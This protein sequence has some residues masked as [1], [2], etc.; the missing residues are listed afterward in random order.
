MNHFIYIHILKSN[1]K[2]EEKMEQLLNVGVIG[3][4]NCGGQIAD[5]ASAEGFEAIAINASSDDMRLLVNKVEC[6]LVGDGK[7]TG[8]NRENAKEF[9]RAHSNIFKDDRLVKFVTD[10][11][12]IVVVASIGGGFGSGASL[13]ATSTLSNDYPDRL[14]IPAGIMPFDSEGYTAQN[15]SIEWEQELEEMQIPY[16]LYDNDRY[17][18]KPE[19]EV[20]NIVNSN[21]IND[22]KVIRG[23][24]IYATRIGGIDARDIMTTLSTPGRIVIGSMV[25]ISDEDVIEKSLIT[26]IK[27]HIDTETAHAAMVDDKQILASATMYCLPEEFDLFKGTIRSDLQNTYG[28]HISDY[29]N[30]ADI[31]DDTHT[32]VPPCIA[33][34]LAGLTAP[35]TRIGKIVKRRDRL[36]TGITTR[37]P[38]ESKVRNLETSG[39]LTL[40]AK[41]FGGVPTRNTV[42]VDQVLSKYTGAANPSQMQG[43]ENQK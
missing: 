27:H 37:K 31:T 20:C 32:D 43:K 8:K 21:V 11:D 5:L 19:K 12:V 33:V 29:A 1:L 7:G 23:D 3:M 28:V 30:F 26:T 34:I 2:E 22:L 18:G 10:H 39:K 25:D 15:H 14:F 24:L 42:N 40:G 36:A 16:L 13:E 4:G 9:L 38:A 41:S 35:Q 17:I 6:F